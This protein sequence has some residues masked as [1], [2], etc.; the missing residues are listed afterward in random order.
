ML[1]N[2]SLTLMASLMSDF[3]NRSDLPR[4]MDFL[5]GPSKSSMRVEAENTL[6][7]FT[8]SERGL[9]KGDEGGGELMC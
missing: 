6:A 9:M 8:C 3:K 2:M 1:L 5:V 7:F 4:A